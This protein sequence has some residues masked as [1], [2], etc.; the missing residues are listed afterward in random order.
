MTPQECPLPEVAEALAP[1]IKPR[2]E[3][4]AIRQELQ[5]HLTK[6]LAR[7]EVPVSSVTLTDQ[8]F[9]QPP[10]TSA[11][12]TGVRKAYLQALRA[13]A[14]AQTRYD[15]LKADLSRLSGSTEQGLHALTSTTITV[16]DVHI[17]LLRQRERL[18]KLQVVD[19]TFSQISAAGK[20]ATVSHLDDVVQHRAGELPVPPTTRPP[21]FGTKPDVETRILQLKKAV[22]ATKRRV[23]AGP[24]HHDPSLQ[25]KDP[26]RSAV[27]AEVAGLRSALAE[28]TGWMEQQLAV[29]GEAEADAEMVSAT[30]RAH[31]NG[32]P[33]IASLE[34]IEAVYEDYLSARYHLLQTLNTPPTTI[35]SIAAPKSTPITIID[36]VEKHPTPAE[37]L[38]PH[39]TTLASTKAAEQSL[40]RQSTNIRRGISSAEAETS[41][42]LARLADESFLVH[43]G[44]DSRGGKAWAEA[45]AEAAKATQELVTGRVAE[46]T[47]SVAKARQGLK[48]IE[49]CVG[50]AERLV[51]G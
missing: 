3:V 8:R 23:E 19:R 10:E 24:V 5:N 45:S 21:S 4:T 35:A 36:G 44:A 14:T 20:D 25:D 16:H 41:R 33:R 26:A 37:L 2:N 6:Q 9:T 42:L 22:L 32:A 15:S 46:G 40:L 27:E 29:I 51:V 13:H 11:A 39:I 12:L 50:M 7:S 30:P 49:E 17:P 38:L 1:Y 48:A 34:D 28:L 31:G 47:K 43:P 18:R